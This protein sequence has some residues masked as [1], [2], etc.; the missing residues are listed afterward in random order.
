VLLHAIEFFSGDWE[1]TE[2]DIVLYFVT[3]RRSFNSEAVNLTKYETSYL[4][5]EGEVYTCESYSYI[6][7]SILKILTKKG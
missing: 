5:S 6:K 7:H 2:L 4:I 1:G 3:P